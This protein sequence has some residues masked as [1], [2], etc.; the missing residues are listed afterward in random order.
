MAGY[1]TAPAVT[2]FKIDTAALDQLRDRC[3]QIARFG[4][5]IVAKYAGTMLRFSESITPKIEF[6]VLGGLRKIDTSAFGLGVSKAFDDLGWQEPK[7]YRVPTYAEIVE[8]PD[9]AAITVELE[10][11]AC[12]NPMWATVDR[13]EQIIGALA[14]HGRHEWWRY[15][16]TLAVGV[17]GA[18]GIDR[19]I[20]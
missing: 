18:F 19:L 13:L 8:S 17:A 3:S 5:E 2:S 16:L 12:E 4:D 9:Y 20:G 6:G 15:A 11:G 1:A 7:P 10:A 14:A